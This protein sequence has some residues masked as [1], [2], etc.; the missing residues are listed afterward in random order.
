MIYLNDHL[1][2]FDLQ[3]ALGQLSVQRREQ[4][5]R[6]R[7]ELGQRTCVTAYLLLREGLKKEY[8]LDEPP[9]FDYG[10]HGKPVI[11]GHPEIHFNLSHCREAAIC[12]LSDKPVGIDIET[13]HE[14]KPALVEYTMND[15]EQRLIFS[16]P[17]PDL[18]FTRLWTR[19]EA[20]VKWSGKGIDNDLKT[21]LT[22]LP[23]PIETLE[24]QDGR[25][26]YSICC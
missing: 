24:S 13:I 22:H 23:H 3:A 2:D 12:A 1:F 7:H 15:D 8:G 19:K 26:V 14:A 11:A 17:H 25:Y 6:F 4:A 5:L 9:L 10:P 16:S 21:V 18:A 20:A